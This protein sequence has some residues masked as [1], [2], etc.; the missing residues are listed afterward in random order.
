V[1]SKI[2]L[3]L[4]TLQVASIST[5]H[6]VSASNAIVRPRLSTDEVENQIVL[7]KKAN[8]LYESNLLAPIREWKNG[9]AE[10]TGFNWSIDYNALFMGV[11]DTGMEKWCG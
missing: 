9:V 11:S 2:Y 5:V 6:A 3:L 10:R 8:P 1:K 7:D 4:I